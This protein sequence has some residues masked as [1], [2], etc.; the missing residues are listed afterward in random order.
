[1]VVPVIHEIS[2]ILPASPWY[3]EDFFRNWGH[4]VYLLDGQPP[5]RFRILTPGFYFFR[6]TEMHH[7]GY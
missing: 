1:M 6:K 5:F 3:V 4:V 2:K 7:F